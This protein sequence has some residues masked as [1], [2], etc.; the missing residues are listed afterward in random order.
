MFNH[1]DAGFNNANRIIKI[2]E[3]FLILKL[4]REIRQRESVNQPIS[5]W[6]MSSI[7]FKC[8]NLRNFIRNSK[9]MIENSLSGLDLIDFKNEGLKKINTV[10]QKIINNFITLTK[11]DKLLWHKQEEGALKGAIAENCAFSDYRIIIKKDF[12]SPEEILKLRVGYLSEKY[13]IFFMKGV[14]AFDKLEYI[15][16][17]DG[18]CIDPIN[19]LIEMIEK[20]LVQQSN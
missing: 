14:L 20:K 4:P 15:S 3:K 17:S 1:I 8:G 2:C 18:K 10:E 6:N 16:D 13:K 12:L 11:E 19:D 7:K 5:G 9:I